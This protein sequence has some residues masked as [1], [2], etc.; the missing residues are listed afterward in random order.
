VSCGKSHTSD[1]PAGNDKHK[2]IIEAKHTTNHQK[3][4]IINSFKL[5]AKACA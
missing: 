3:P 2:S 1:N 5:W 4:Y